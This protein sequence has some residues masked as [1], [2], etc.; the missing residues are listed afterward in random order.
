VRSAIGSRARPCAQMP[1]VLALRIKTRAVTCIRVSVATPKWRC[2]RP[3]SRSLVNMPVVLSTAR[4]LA[5]GERKIAAF[6]NNRHQAAQLKNAACR[7]DGV[8][9]S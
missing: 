7:N 5:K 4:L 1:N 8:P 9:W 6:L 3:G 2:G